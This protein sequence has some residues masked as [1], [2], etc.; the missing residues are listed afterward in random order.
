MIIFTF[1]SRKTKT[2]IIKD[3]WNRINNRNP[4][5]LIRSSLSNSLRRSINRV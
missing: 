5:C 4:L 3:I 1:A 2:L